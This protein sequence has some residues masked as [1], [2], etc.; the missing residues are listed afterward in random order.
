MVPAF[1]YEDG[2]MSPVGAYL[3]PEGIEPGTTVFVDSVLHTPHML[4]EGPFRRYDSHG[5]WDGR[6]IEISYYEDLPVVG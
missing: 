6:D 5:V 2:A 1:R 4:S 3:L